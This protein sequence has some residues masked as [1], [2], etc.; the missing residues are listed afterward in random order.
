MR[1]KKTDNIFKALLQKKTKTW[2]K[3]NK[4]Q[5]KQQNSLKK[6]VS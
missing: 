6:V 3:S 4:N 1:A 2:G 5:V